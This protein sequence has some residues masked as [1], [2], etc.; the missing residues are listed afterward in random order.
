MRWQRAAALLALVLATAACGGRTPVVRD[1]SGA[2]CMRLSSERQVRGETLCEDVFSCI[3]PP[4]SLVDRIGL[5]RLAL[6]GG[7]GGP[8]VLFLPGMHM[9]GEVATTDARYDLRLYLAQAGIR[10]WSL[11]YRTHNIPADASQEQLQALAGWSRSIFLKDADWAAAFVRGADPGPLYLAGFS[12]GAGLAYGLASSGDQPIAGLIIID[13]VPSGNDRAQDSG[14]SAIDVAGSR[15]PYADRQR[16]LRAVI[17]SP[18]GPSPVGGYATAGAALADIVYT[19]PAF[20]GEGGLSAARNGVSDVRVL[21]QLLD[22]E[23]RWWPRAASDGSGASGPRHKLPVIA[24]ASGNMGPAWI[25][26][27]TDGAKRFGGDKT[28]VRDVPLHGHLDMLVGRLAASEV[29]EP[30]RRW[31]MTSK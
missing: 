11:D 25:T 18:N 29:Y 21:A 24:F 12:Y 4:G 22:A 31:L 1:N 20:G 8:V 27:V 9:N 19:S 30:T 2:A 28:T 16:L 10:A 23:D 15:L 13:G 7:A 26:Q 3:R 17:A 5:R 14:G 6:C